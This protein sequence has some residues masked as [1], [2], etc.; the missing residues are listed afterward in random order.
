ML[1]CRKEISMDMY[2]KLGK[3]YL[4]YCDCGIIYDRQGTELV[5]I[6]NDEVDL[7]GIKQTGIYIEKSRWKPK[8]KE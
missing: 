4:L 2:Q 5:P 3:K 7:K 8:E 1:N 6:P